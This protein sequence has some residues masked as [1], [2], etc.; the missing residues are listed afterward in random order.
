MGF[1]SRG[2]ACNKNPAGGPHVPSFGICGTFRL[3]N[4]EC[5]NG[6]SS[7]PHSTPSPT[8]WGD[9]RKPAASQLAEKLAWAT[10]SYQGAASAAPNAT[11]LRQPPPNPPRLCGPLP[12]PSPLTMKPVPDRRSR[13]GTPY[14]S[15][16]LQGWEGKAPNQFLSAEGLRGGAAGT[17]I[18]NAFAPSCALG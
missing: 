16:A 11:D 14:P 12:N 2:N 17:P 8:S 6:L 7:S 13:A 10:D 1:F 15:P 9:R 5:H 18:K 4:N 3:G